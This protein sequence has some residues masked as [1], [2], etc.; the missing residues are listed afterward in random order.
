MK[1]EAGAI[2]RNLYSLVLTMIAWI[3]PI[4]LFTVFNKDIQS[5]DIYIAYRTGNLLEHQLVSVILLGGMHWL[6]DR[7]SVV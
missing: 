2:F 7:K 3:I 4:A 1:I 6:L 5:S